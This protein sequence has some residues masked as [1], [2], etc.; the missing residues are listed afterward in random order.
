MKMADVVRERWVQRTGYRWNVE[1]W[2][3]DVEFYTK[4]P[5]PNRE[6]NNFFRLMTDNY[7]FK[8]DE[9]V[10]DIG[11]GAGQYSIALSKFAKKVVGLDFSGKMIEAAK[12][13]AAT[14]GA[15]NVEF[16]QMNWADVST[17]D[18]LLKGGYDIVFAHTTPAIGG[19]NAF[20]KMLRTANRMCFYSFP[21]RRKDRLMEDVW[22]NLN[23]NKASTSGLAFD[24]D[25]IQ[26][27]FALIWE[28]GAHPQFDYET[29]IVW[30][31]KRPFNSVMA[32]CKA[33]AAKYGGFTADEEKKVAAYL[34]TL[35]GA[36]GLIPSRTDTEIV[37][38][39]W[40]IERKE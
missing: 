8:G 20:D 17:D 11:C 7:D 34:E 28:S 38:I 2:D 15:D 35:I 37:N 4:Y 40:K 5:I 18:P 9:T 24:E 31:E 23:P 10:L 12:K 29:D 3:E 25:I 22:R 27:A 30:E 32:G 13:S 14:H 26:Y 39:F 6:N 36:D 33:G 1:A 21:V 19:A 16:V